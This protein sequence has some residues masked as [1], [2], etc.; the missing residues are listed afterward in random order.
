ML[1]KKAQT[2]S[3][4]PILVFIICLT[5]F[6]VAFHSNFQYSLALL[7]ILIVFVIAFV[8]INVALIILILSMLLS[9]EFEAG[10]VLGR[11]V[12]IR[13]EDVLLLV[14]FLGWMA[15][16][17]VT[18]EAGL[19]R[20]TPLNLPIGLYAFFC[21]VATGFKMIE[22]GNLSLMQSSFF[23][24]LKY[25]EYY[26]LF[27]MVVNNLQTL[28]QAKL[29]VFFILLTC[30]FVSLYGASLIP[31]GE[32]LTAPFEGKEGGE[33]NTFAAYLLLMMALI[34]GLFLYSRSIR[35]RFLLLCLLAV[36]AVVFLLTLSRGGWLGAFPMILT[37]I[38]LNKRYRHVL[39]IV[40]MLF[41]I[42]MPYLLPQKVLNRYQDIF[43]HEKT[44][45]L[46]G[47]KYSFSESTA[48]RIDGWRRGA[49]EW[50]KK[51]FFGWGVPLGNVIDNQYTRVLLETGFFGLMAYLWLLMA[52]F[53]VCWR[54]FAST[55]DSFAKGVSLGVI[56]GFMGLLTNALAAAT[57]IL[58]RVMEPFWF[59]VAIVVV[60]PDLLAQEQA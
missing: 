36:A 10:G 52:I 47:K 32:R 26:L 20:K 43:S 9:P 35:Q 1:K 7:G 14:V 30:F 54:S 57:F 51:P 12:V 5:P 58:I 29:F 2:V 39:I 60:L 23:Y 17:A 31:S 25:F 24:L 45:N 44:Y 11:S 53:K 46:L 27:F 3:S 13:I 28:K 15:R 18:K 33:P 19:F 8:K 38:F 34:L 55:E 16:M 41:L 37:F 56:A 4:L 40:F 50:A 48:N 22:I 59:L 6:L 49:N 42:S 21:L